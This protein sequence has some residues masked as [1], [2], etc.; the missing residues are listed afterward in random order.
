MC[1]M[2]APL[3]IATPR[4]LLRQICS[5]DLASFASMNADSRV[6]EFFPR[7]LSPDESQS[8]LIRIQEGFSEMG[9]GVYAIEAAGS[10]AGIGGLSVPGFKASFTPCVE[11]LWRLLPEFWGHGYATE[12]ARAIL[13]MA[14]ETLA[15]REIVS[16]AVA[17]NTKSIRVME[18]AGMHRDMDG[19]FDHPLVDAPPLKRHVL[20]RARLTV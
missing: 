7:P 12:A 13:S 15:L 19:D 2:T 16:F 17:G 4:L 6:M 8:T 3:E 11:I 18:K 5:I 9:F 14:F 10:F 1:I 20:Y